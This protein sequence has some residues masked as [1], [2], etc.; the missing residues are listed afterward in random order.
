MDRE[1]VERRRASEENCASRGP[2]DSPENPSPAEVEE[3]LAAAA[4]VDHK[5]HWRQYVKHLMNPGYHW[6]RFKEDLGASRHAL[7][8]LDLSKIDTD[9][10]SLAKAFRG[11]LFACFWLSG[12]FGIFGPI[13]GTAVQV[14]TADPLLGLLVTFGVA[15]LFGS[16][17]MQIIWKAAHWNLY[18][19][20]SKRWLGWIAPLERDLLPMQGRAFLL[21][22]VLFAIM[23]PI[24]LLMVLVL[25]THP[26]LARFVPMGIVAPLLDLLIINSPLLR[27]MGDIFER[28]GKLLAARYARPVDEIAS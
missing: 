5:I 3:T 25:H 10:E 7:A 4:E 28:H 22:C 16:I 13:T 8:T 18:R 11:R 17:G 27:I 24:N 9:R 14:A 23:L 19:R 15:N 12:M 2:A 6:R 1:F 21:V 20:Q 26:N